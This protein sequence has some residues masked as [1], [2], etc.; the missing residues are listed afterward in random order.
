MSEDTQISI[1]TTTE[2]VNVDVTETLQPVSLECYFASGS[3]L[4]TVVN[5]SETVQNIEL[6]ITET[7]AQNVTVD[8][9]YPIGPQGIQGLSGLQGPVGPQGPQGLS[10]QQGPVGP[11][12]QSI[13]GTISGTLSTQTDL[14]KYLSA[15]GTS[16][17]DIATLNTYLSTNTIT[18]CS[19]NTKGQILSTGIDLFNIFSTN[20]FVNSK[21]LP[22]TGGNIQGTL[23]VVGNIS[24]NNLRTSF[25]LGS[26]TGDYSFA[27]NLGRAFGDYSHAEGYQ[28]IASGNYSHA[29]GYLTI[30]S[31]L[32]SHAEG[33]RTQG[34]NN[35]A[36]AEGEQTR[37]TGYC[38]HAEGDSS[39]ASGARSHAEGDTAVASGS[40]SHAA[41][42]KATAAHNYTYAWSDGNLGTTTTNISTTRTCQYMVSAS[43]GMFIP[44]KVGIGIDSYSTALSSN[45]LLVNG[46]TYINNNLT[47]KGNLSAAGTATF[48]NTVF[49]V[50]SALCAVANSSQPALYVGQL[51]TG[52]LAS[53]YDLNPIP[54]EVLHV[55]GSVGIPGVG[56]YTSVPNKALTVVGEISATSNITNTG[57]I[58]T[59]GGNSD[60]WNSA[61]TV[62]TTYQSASSSFATNTT[63]NSVSSLLTP[64]TLTKT[65]TGLLTPLTTTNTLTGQLLLTSTYQSASSSFATTKESSPL[66]F[67]GDLFG[68]NFVSLINSTSSTALPSLT[69]ITITAGLMT[70]SAGINSFA[71]AAGWGSQ[72]YTIGA[73]NPG[74]AIANNEYFTIPVSSTNN[75]CTI[76][77]SSLAAF[78]VDRST[79][80]PAF[81]GLLYGTSSDPSLANTIATATVLTT[82]SDISPGFNT[83]LA[84]NNIII[85][86]GTTGYIFLV[87]YGAG[88]NTGNLRFISNNPLG[89]INDLSFQGN[90][91]TSFIYNNLTLVNNLTAQNGVLT[92]S[93][94]NVRGNLSSVNDIEITDPTKGI[95]LRSPNNTKWRITV[96]N[97]GALSSVQL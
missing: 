61:Y 54:V 79:N 71:S 32:M 50:T 31:G 24:G 73:S 9:I 10:G 22:L 80:G 15:V 47:V 20:Q 66:V 65:L 34:T 8:V 83:A 56:I 4:D 3:V 43:G 40:A 72:G 87:P 60:N 89:D 39:V 29:E 52:D 57:K 2:I 1:S 49:S 90:I 27:E 28:T 23:T 94:L 26:A 55:G 51:G 45:T 96:T 67:S 18:L 93:T 78:P 33:N 69:A 92:T 41:G 17:F 82:P 70:R 48:Y 36:H 59:T 7:E 91:T 74:A 97:A 12:G 84:T 42:Y 19:T 11:Q 44:G 68:Y 21:F 35:Y 76:K 53:F 95:I 75:T 6:Y 81:I 63:L 46:D 25:N 88:T 14:W 58:Y 64:L 38:S 85:P 62:A 37:A 77:I 16:N 5:I 86:P 30:A 13:W